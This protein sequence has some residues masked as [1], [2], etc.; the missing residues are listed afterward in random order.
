MFLAIG[1]DTGSVRPQFQRQFEDSHV[2]FSC[3]SKVAAQPGAGGACG[4]NGNPQTCPT[5]GDRHLESPPWPGGPKNTQS[6][7]SNSVL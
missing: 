1:G 6:P 2:L 4:D 3:S 7:N 5:L